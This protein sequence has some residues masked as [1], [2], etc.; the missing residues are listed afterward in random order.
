MICTDGMPA[1]AQNRLL[2]QL[3]LAGAQLRYHGDFDWAGLHIGNYVMREYNACPWRFGAADLLR[4]FGQ[5]RVQVIVSRARRCLRR[6][7][8]NCRRR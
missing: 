6:G 1:A 5:P 7:T 2:S 3:A 4:P 8:H